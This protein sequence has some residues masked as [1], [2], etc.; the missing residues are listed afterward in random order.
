M[1]S[2]GEVGGVAARSKPREESERAESEARGAIAG[3]DEKRRARLWAEA[4][5]MWWVFQLGERD[6][7]IVRCFCV[8][9]SRYDFQVVKK[10]RCSLVLEATQS[11]FG[12]WLIVAGSLLFGGAFPEKVA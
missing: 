2:K 4:Q 10:R 9:P 8:I 1:G 6:G 5:Y 12:G 11:T 3:V 7:L